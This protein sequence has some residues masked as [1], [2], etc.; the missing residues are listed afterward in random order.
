MKLCCVLEWNK[1]ENPSTRTLFFLRNDSKFLQINKIQIM[2][3]PRCSGP[4]PNLLIVLNKCQNRLQIMKALPHHAVQPAS[5]QAWREIRPIPGH[6]SGQAGKACQLIALPSLCKARG[7]TPTPS[8]EL[9]GWCSPVSCSH[10]GKMSL[11]R[12]SVGSDCL[13]TLDKVPLWQHLGH[14]G[15]A[16][17]IAACSAGWF[18][19]LDGFGLGFTK[20]WVEQ[21]DKRSNPCALQRS[22]RLKVSKS[23][24]SS[25][26]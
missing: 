6:F 16:F 20:A 4:D 18:W 9:L 19:D 15:E 21:I 25:V 11:P 7:Q 24:G 17:L 2:H 3:F 26:E 10:L 22:F 12:S 14:V 8:H 5:K 13:H 1:L 23:Q